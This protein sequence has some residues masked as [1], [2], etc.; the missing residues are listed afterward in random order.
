M[1]NSKSNY[2]D[3]NN[4]KDKLADISDYDSLDLLIERHNYK[5]DK[6]IKISLLLPTRN[7]IEHLDRLFQSLIR[8]SCNLEYIEVVIY[9]D[10][11]D[12][13]TREFVN[14]DVS[15]LKIIGPRLT[16][17]QYNS[18][19]YRYCSGNII[20]L[21]N[22]DV[23][24]ET[25]NWDKLLIKEIDKIDDEIYLAYPNDG[26]N[27]DKLSTFPI[28]SRKTCE[29]LVYPYPPLYKRLF[30][31]THLMD[32][33][34]RL[35]NKSYE[36]IIYLADIKFTHLKL[37]SHH[38]NNESFQRTDCHDDFAF[39]SLRDLRELQAARLQ[40]IIENTEVPLIN[41]TYTLS[42]RHKNY[43]N[44]CRWFHDN[45]LGDKG[46]PLIIR[47]KYFVRFAGHFFMIKTAFGMF[48]SKTYNMFRRNK[49]DSIAY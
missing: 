33:F 7:R 30:I 12:S 34:K 43:L 42:D 20:M 1:L 46:L 14:E 11:D 8:K 15:I 41:D 23:I 4:L 32:V 6:K 31:D 3:K 36:R 28:L 25:S 40:S 39:I 17:G 2:H 9:V 49:I 29:A 38:D 19:C 22:D 44:C 27:Q 21:I 13:S 26:F 47:I 45:F 18:V 16:M 10:D 5:K 35:V 37:N 24:I 48:V